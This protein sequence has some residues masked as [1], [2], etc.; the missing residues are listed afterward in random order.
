MGETAFSVPLTGL[1]DITRAAV[2]VVAQARSAP[3]PVALV[4]VV[5]A[6]LHKVFLQPQARRGPALAVVVAVSRALRKP[7][8]T[9]ARPFNT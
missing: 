3:L 8:Q 9:V 7:E 1:Q 5:T 2:V 4:S 6:A